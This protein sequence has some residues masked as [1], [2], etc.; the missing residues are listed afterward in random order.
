M[1]SSVDDRASPGFGLTMDFQIVR[2]VNRLRAGPAS[3]LRLFAQQFKSKFQ[4]GSPVRMQPSASCKNRFPVRL[5]LPSTDG[6][7]SNKKQVRSYKTRRTC[8]PA[9]PRCHD[10][11]QSGQPRPAMGQLWPTALSDFL[12]AYSDAVVVD[13]ASSLAGERPPAQGP[14]QK[15]RHC[16]SS[17]TL[18]MPFAQ[19]RHT[20]GHR[21]PYST[22]K[23]GSLLHKSVMPIQHIS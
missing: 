17:V 22:K 16:P 7:F 23:H 15:R 9:R 10:P 2:P 13:G 8:W 19:A 3:G 4:D 21:P 12:A 14:R 5:S 11:D 6:T 20:Q 1:R 18:G